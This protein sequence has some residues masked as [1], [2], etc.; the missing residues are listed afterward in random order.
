MITIITKSSCWYCRG[1]IQFL[2]SLDLEYTEIEISRDPDTY[3]KY[4][5]I[6]GMRTVPQIFN[7]EATKQN[8]VGGY[9]EMMKQYEAWEIFKK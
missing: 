2:D 9:D 3:Q 6:S 4:K 5:D 7:W 1:A 8:L